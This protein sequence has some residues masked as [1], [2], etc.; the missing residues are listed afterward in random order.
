MNEQRN[1]V[2]SCDSQQKVFSDC[3]CDPVNETNKE[4]IL[5]SAQTVSTNW[6]G[7]DFF[8]TLNCDPDSNCEGW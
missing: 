8:V 6:P 4:K 3:L 7:Q 2:Q 5:E 1:M